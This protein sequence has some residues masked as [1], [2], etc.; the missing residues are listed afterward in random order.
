[1]NAPAPGS[2]EWLRFMTASK[3]A[4]VVGTSPYESKFSLWHKMHGDIPSGHVTDN[5]IFNYGHYLEPVLLKWFGDQHPEVEV[6]R[7]EWTTTDGEF[8]DRFGAT[9]DGEFYGTGT[10]GIVEAKTSRL[11]WEWDNG[12]PAGY[13]DQVQW[14]LFVTGEQVAYVVADVSME[15]REYRVER[16][17]ARINHL[18]GEARAFMASLA[19]GTPPPIDGSAHTYQ[20]VR[21]LHPEID[22]EDVEIP[23]DLAVRWLDE[24]E[25]LAEFTEREQRAKSEIAALMGT[26]RRAV[27]NGHA[28]FTRQARGGGTPYLVA[29]RN[30]PTGA[31]A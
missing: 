23:D 20:A 9:P 10:S 16:D 29:G 7:G 1:V 14:T 15:F 18:V 21:E 26:A 12:V 31:A 19:A 30:L 4:A 27:W 24:R 8:G 22:P 6:V 5:P 3:I 25:S 28:L 11:S 2:P 17:E 13:Y